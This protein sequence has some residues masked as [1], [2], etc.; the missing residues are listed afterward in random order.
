MNS[1]KGTCSIKVKYQ[2]FGPRV[3]ATASVKI[4]TPFSIL[5]LASGPN[6]SSFAAWCWRDV[7]NA[8]ASLGLRSL[9][10]NSC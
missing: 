4:S 3:T 1:K 6:L 8:W 7:L 9:G 2:T 5:D 10:E